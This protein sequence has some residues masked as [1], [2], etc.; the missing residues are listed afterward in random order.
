[1]LQA[2]C[3]LCCCWFLILVS[4]VS[5][6]PCSP[7]EGLAEA[8]QGVHPLPDQLEN[9]FGTRID[10]FGGWGCG[11]VEKSDVSRGNSYPTS[12][13]QNWPWH[14]FVVVEFLFFLRLINL[15]LK[16][17]DF[18]VVVNFYFSFAFFC[19]FSINLGWASTVFTS[20]PLNPFL[21]IVGCF[22]LHLLAA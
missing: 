8:V 21:V 11:G 17:L 2:L 20:H 19:C 9:G 18:F 12:A 10:E 13:L 7:E 16:Y 3:W 22:I 5:C 6:C 4:S 14:A 1:M 15:C